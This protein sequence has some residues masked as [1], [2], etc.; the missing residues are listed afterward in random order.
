M[1]AGAVWCAGCAVAAVKGFADACCKGEE[2]IARDVACPE[3]KESVRS[4]KG[5]VASPVEVELKQSWR[6]IVI[7]SLIS[8]SASASLSSV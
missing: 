4:R 3:D 6:D 8:V 7:I 1:A 5:V 2:D